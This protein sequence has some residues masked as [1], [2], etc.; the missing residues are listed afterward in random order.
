MSAASAAR[1]ADPEADIT[2]FTE[3]RD[4]AYSPCMIP[5]VLEGKSTWNEMIMHDPAWYAKERNIKIMPS[6]NNNVPAIC[7]L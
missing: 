2:V 4:V 3:D 5:W 7:D 1:A 6:R